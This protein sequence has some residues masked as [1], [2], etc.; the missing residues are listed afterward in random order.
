MV[1]HKMT[2]TECR[3]ALAK[4]EVA[5]LA[6]ESNGQPYVVPVYLAY[7]GKP[8]YGFSTVGQ[9]IEFMRANPLVCMEVDDVKSQIHWMSV[10]VFGRY[11]ELP[12]TPEYFAARSHA[13]ELLQKRPS[14]GN[15][16]I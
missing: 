8:L 13:L 15:L 1:I 3:K 2:L 4:A 12:D 11:E 5:R 9:K 10:I 7:D 14:G 6:C 16:R